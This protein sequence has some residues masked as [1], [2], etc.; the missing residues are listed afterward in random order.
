MVIVDPAEEGLADTAGS[1]P[2]LVNQPNIKPNP[3]QPRTQHAAD[4]GPNR[5]ATGE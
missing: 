3:T 4:I 5:K 2:A 1:Y